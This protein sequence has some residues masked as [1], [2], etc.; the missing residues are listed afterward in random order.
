MYKTFKNNI[1]INFHWVHF[2]VLSLS[3]FATVTAWYLV[4]QQNE[5]RIV[6]QFNREADQNIS[7]V[8]ER[9]KKYEEALWAGVALFKA[10]NDVNFNEWKDFVNT[11]NIA[12]RYK[13]INGLGIIFNIDKNDISL[14]EKKI[15]KYQPNFKVYPQHNNDFILPIT[16]IEPLEKNFKAHGLDVA[17]EQNRLTAALKAKETGLAQITGPIVLVQDSEKT[18]GFLFYAPFYE[19]AD[20]SVFKGMVYAPFVVKSLMAGLLDRANRHV[21]I[22]INDKKEILYEE[23]ISN[24]SHLKINRE[25]EIYGR[26]WTFHIQADD[27]FYE[28]TKSNQPYL[29]LFGGLII[30]ALLLIVFVILTNQKKEAEQ[31]A[32]EVSQKYEAEI[33]T[34]M[35][36]EL[37]ASKASKAKGDFLANMSH[38]IR[39][40]MNGILG[41]T[42]ILIDDKTISEENRQLL[43]M[44]HDSGNILLSIVNDI[45]DFS[46]IESEKLDLHETYFNLENCLEACIYMLN[47][48]ASQNSVEVSL[49]LMIPKNLFILSDEIRFKQIIINLL[50][51]AVK[52]TKNGKVII[53]V[54]CDGEN[55]KNIKI[56]IIDTGIGITEENLKRLFSP[57]T[58]ADHQT[59]VEFGGTGLGLS[60]SK[61]LANAMNGDV[62][63]KSEIGVGSVFIYTFYAATKIL[64]TDKAIKEEAKVE[65][66]VFYQKVLIAEDNLINQKMME[67]IL[68]KLQVTFDIV[69][70]GKKAIEKIKSEN[71]DLIFMDVRMPVMDGLEATRIIKSLPLKHRM[72]LIVG[73]TA[74]ATTQDREECIANGMDDY[75]SKPAKLKDIQKC[76]QKYK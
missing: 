17:H 62:T 50:S 70:N 66:K 36:A 6:S 35:K 64:D 37:E 73:L 2:L 18:P 65:K 39:T 75:I 31:I 76:L 61:E 7:L 53:K 56:E 16:Y 41:I 63:A 33:K 68:K 59:S 45:L 38:E 72:P 28:K 27:L 54:T 47:R 69:S 52:F 55:N 25:V 26:Q 44:V 1:K 5:Q 32:S 29:V 58:Q 30:D 11:F 9:L 8:V 20:R 57:F 22:Q 19:N 67:Q 40:P 4:D 48:K 51:N 15:S 71:F 13:G 21:S 14:L 60:I 3:I 34:R 49:D 10:T 46:K 74:N 42:D 12:E 23:K 24:S 43:S